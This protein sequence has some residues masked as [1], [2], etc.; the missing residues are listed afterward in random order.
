MKKTINGT[1]SALAI[2]LWGV[3]SLALASGTWDSSGA[4][5]NYMGGPVAIGVT[6]TP[7]TFEAVGAHVSGVGMGRF[8]GSSAH[9]YFTLDSSAAGESGFLLSNNGQLIGQF[10]VTAASNAVFV[11]NRQFGTGQLLTITSAGKVGIGVGATN[12][13][14]QL[15]VDGTIEA[16]EIIVHSTLGADYVFEKDYKMA[17]LD[18]LEQYIEEHKHLPGIPSAAEMQ[19]TGMEVGALNTMLLAKIEELTLHV[20]QLNKE[21]SELTE[22]VSEIQKLVVKESD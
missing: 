21:K 15:S 12:P 17:S 1:F 9:G 20:I 14:Y 18:D 3:S 16:K 13:A 2:A 4:V 19:T 10:G 22:K 5:L 6:T 11:K 8:K 7:V